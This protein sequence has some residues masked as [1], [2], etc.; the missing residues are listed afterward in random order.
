MT[1]LRGAP[2]V[3]VKAF[4]SAVYGSELVQLLLG[5]R[6]HPGGDELTRR[7]ADLTG[8]GPGDRVLDVASGL[9][10]TARLLSAE[11]GAVVHGVELSPRLVMQAEREAAEAGLDDLAS[12]EVGDAEHLSVDDA[13]FDAVVCECALCTFPDQAAAVAGFRRVLRPG[14]RVAIADITL[15]RDRLPPELDTPIGRVACIAGALPASGYERLLRANGFADIVVE[16][17]PDAALA[18]VDRIREGLGAAREVLRGLFDVGEA[19]RLVDLARDAVREGA[20]G[21]ALIAAT[22][23]EAK[24]DVG[25]VAGGHGADGPLD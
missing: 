9:G 20:I 23:G 4:C 12:F 8:I 25:A 6:L 7:L 3:D 24:P 21:Y 19:L 10:T 22:V 16:P 17:H 14:G 15:D 1:D 11:R 5:G 18:T 13:S 2:I